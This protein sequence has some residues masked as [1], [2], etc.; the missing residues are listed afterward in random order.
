[1]L[2]PRLAVS[3]LLG[4]LA[5]G[6]QRHC[7]CPSDPVPDAAGRESPGPPDV[8]P[9]QA[10][11]GFLPLAPLA[12]DLWPPPPSKGSLFA[13]SPAETG[14][15]KLEATPASATRPGRDYRTLTGELQYLHVRNVWRLRFGGEDDRYG[16][17]VTLTDAGPLAEYRSGQRVRVEGELVD[18]TATEPSPD[19]RVRRIEPAS[20]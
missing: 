15:R 10:D 4:L 9:P 13:G 20:P 14:D 1:M 8:P 19:Y 2:R 11:S 17:S 12:L 7:L 6:C 16:G 5:A 18:P 3:V